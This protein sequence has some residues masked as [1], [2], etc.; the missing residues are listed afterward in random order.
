MRASVGF[1]RHDDH[2]NNMPES[3]DEWVE[4]IAEAS[5][6]A[7]NRVFADHIDEYPDPDSVNGRVPDVVVN[8]GLGREVIE[9]DSGH[10]D[11]DR[12]QIDDIQSG[13]GPFDSFDRVVLEEDRDDAGLFSFF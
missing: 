13:L 12:N 2:L 5:D 4:E 9:V 8:D 11:R 7:T 6:T 3:H 10:S 1:F